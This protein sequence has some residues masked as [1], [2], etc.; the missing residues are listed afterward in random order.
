MRSPHPPH[1]PSPWSSPFTQVYIS[2]CPHLNCTPAQVFPSS[3][4]AATTLTAYSTAA[5]HLDKSPCVV[6]DLADDCKFFVGVFVRQ[7]VCGVPLLLPQADSW[8]CSP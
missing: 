1:P 4:G 2:A 5:F 7:P 6:N 8:A 3:Y